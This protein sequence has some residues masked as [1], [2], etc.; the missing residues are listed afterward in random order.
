MAD[1]AAK[2]ASVA[3]E[4]RAKAPVEQF[5]IAHKEAAEFVIT[6][7][8][9][10]KLGD[11]ENVKLR[12]EKHMGSSEE[13]KSLHRLCFGR[14]GAKTTVKA[15]LRKFSGLTIE[16]VELERRKT[17]VEKLDGKMIKSLLTICDISTSGTKAQNAAD[18]FAYLQAPKASGKRSIAEIAGEKKAKAERKRARIE[19]KRA[20]K[21]KAAAKGKGKAKG[22]AAA[23]GLKKPLSAFLLYSNN[24]REKVRAPRRPPRG[25]A[26]Q[27]GRAGARSS[28][29][30]R[31]SRGGGH[32][33]PPHR[34][35]AHPPSLPGAGEDRE[36]ER[37]V[38]RGRTHPLGEVEGN[39]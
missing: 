13:L 9:G 4:R 20:K 21:A 5:T 38:R 19:K 26:G 34:P 25:R 3:R 31:P 32:D 16:G 8:K 12:I 17:S 15:N 10:T 1:D 18:L 36:P 35:R 6:D 2:P 39:L 28:P 29:R 11:I 30:R 33:P 22:A 23:A 27:E 24:K 14:P 37:L 7:G